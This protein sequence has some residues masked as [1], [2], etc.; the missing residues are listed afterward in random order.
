MSRSH[1][2]YIFLTIIAVAALSCSPF[3]S[4]TIENQYPAKI[5][6]P[7]EIQSLTLMNRSMSGEFINFNED[8]LQRYFYRKEF[9]VNTN[10][11]DSMASDTCLQAIGE[12]IY[13][14]G[15]FDVVIPVERNIPK[16]SKY[17]IIEQP[18]DWDHVGEVCKTYNTD[19]LLVMEKYVNRVNTRFQAEVDHILPDGSANYSYFYASFDVIYNSFFRI[20]YPKKKE[21]VGQF[22]ISDTIFWENGDVDQRTLFKNLGS[23]KK[24][25]IATGIKVA[26]DLDGYISPSWVPAERGIFII[27]KKNKTEQKLIDA[28]DWAQLA[29]YWQPLTE[30]KNR[31][32]R[33]KAE[34]NMALSSELDGRVDDAIVWAAKSYQSS[35]RNQTDIYIKKLKERKAELLRLE[36]TKAEEK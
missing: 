14:S 33:S 19:A 25:L 20:Y 5:Q 4:V 31:S 30:S 7:E 27:D 9:N 16:D 17:Y 12:L 22:F 13:E 3:R 36:Q 11:L 1:L 35:F 2:S 6:I 26:L 28:S 29:E 18:L 34:F 23:I 8:S 10:V 15:R 24:G 21:I 32:V